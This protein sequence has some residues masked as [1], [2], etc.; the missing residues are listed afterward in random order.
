MLNGQMYKYFVCVNLNAR[1]GSR[2]PLGGLLPGT[3]R[4]EKIIILELARGS[5]GLENGFYAQ[6][7]GKIIIFSI[8]L[9]NSENDGMV[10]CEKCS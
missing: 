3:L 6:T 4:I 9:N 2:K 1:W 7:G 8:N 5:G 10:C